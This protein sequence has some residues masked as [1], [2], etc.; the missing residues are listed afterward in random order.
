MIRKK[1]CLLGTLAVGKT[2]LV[3]RFVSN[4]FSDSYLTTIG[5]KVEQREVS[6]GSKDIEL[7]V[8]DVHGDDE[9][10]RLQASYL[11][12]SSGFLYVIDSTRPESVTALVTLIERLGSSVQNLPFVIFSNKSDLAT[13][14]DFG[15]IKDIACLRN[16]LELIHSS[17]KTGEGVEEGFLSLAKELLK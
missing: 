13:K 10:K 2:S 17:A 5:V 11:R 6:V 8:W 9:F 12:G 1:I 15:S 3:R 14:I 4:T 7:V 16:R